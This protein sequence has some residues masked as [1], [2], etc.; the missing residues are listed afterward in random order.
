MRKGWEV[1]KLKSIA[2]YFIGLTYAP[3]DVSDKGT[4]VL[5]STNVQSGQLDLSD[6]IRVNKTIKENLKVREGDILMCSRNGSKRLVGKI[7]TIR[8]LE[9]EMTFGTFMTVIRSQYN[10]FLSWFFYSDLFREQLSSGENPMISQITKY[11]LDDIKI[12]LPPLPEQKRIV[13]IL[14]E[15]FAAIDKAK[16]NV[17]KNLQNARELFESYLQ[18]VFENK[19]DDWEE[20][21]LED[22]SLTFGR[23]KSKHRPRN[24]EKL[25]GGKYP[26]IQTG[27][28]R[29]SNKHITSYSQTYNETGL[30]QSKLWRKGTI[31]ITI[32]ANIAETGILDFDSCFPDSM[33]GL[34]VDPLKADVNYTY[35]ALQYLKTELKLLGKGSA[36]DNINVGTFE[37]Q[38]FPFPQLKKQKQIS[39]SFDLLSTETKKIEAIYHQKLN[40]FEELKKSILQKAFNGEL[41]K[42]ASDSY[43]INQQEFIAAEPAAIYKRVNT[44][45]LS[46]E[47]EQ[48]LL[49]MCLTIFMHDKK[50]QLATLAEVKM[51]KMCHLAESKIPNLAFNRNPLKEE[52]G[53]AD[54]KR[55][56]RLHDFAE[57]NDIFIYERGA[58]YE[59]YPKGENFMKWVKK[60]LQQ[61]APVVKKQVTALVDLLKPLKTKQIDVLATTYAAWNNLLIRGV[62][63]SFDNIRTEA[64]WHARKFEFT[65]EDFREAIDFLKV[66]YLVPEGKGKLVL[67][68]TV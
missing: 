64:L 4:I 63:D 6:L 45:E 25:Y 11:M 66:N 54:F 49:F 15:T 36:Q 26:F 16:A 1:K 58:S 50:K 13:E 10:P 56:Y 31:C 32:A 59:K 3:S 44:N 39:Q 29:N 47:E 17:E 57:A 5:R 46:E 2:E 24:D 60:A 55:L 51:E 27:D 62:D 8:G 52:Y 37:N 7:A 33:I 20:K 65:D 40:G 53:P 18:S 34:V 23:G 9:E 43:T 42:D 14:D 48:Q 21:K 67:D 22:I 30:A 68:K 12:N 19:G 61:L 41:T 28:V 38:L 35:Y